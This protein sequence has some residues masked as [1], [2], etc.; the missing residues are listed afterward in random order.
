[1][2]ALAVNAF[3]GEP[4][5]WLIFVLAGLLAAARSLQ[6]PSREALEPRTVRHELI[7]AANALSSFG[8]QA[9]VLVGPAIGGL[10]IAYVG[11]GWC[12]VVNIVG[13]VR[14]DRAVRPDAALPAPRRDHPAQPAGDR[15]G[16]PLRASAAATC[17]APTSSTSP[18]CCWRCRW[19][20]SP[21]WR[22]RSSTGPSCSA[23]STPPRRSARC[24]PR[25]SAAGP[26]GSTTTAGRS[27]SPRRRTA[28]SSPWPGWRRRSGWRWGSSCWPGRRT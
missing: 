4:R 27:W 15:R 18:R 23:C 12:Y 24:W 26:H 16:H 11:I 19:C 1:M 17:S 2:A 10:L 20:C 9:G 28:R 25:R 7:T 8:M 13:A 6:R 22:R 5:V 3:V 14:R 21:P